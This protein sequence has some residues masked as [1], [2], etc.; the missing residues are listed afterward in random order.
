MNKRASWV[1]YAKGYGIVLVVYGHVSRGLFNAGLLLDAPRFT[2]IDSVIYSFHMPLFFFLSGL[3]FIPSFNKYGRPALLREKAGSIVYPYLVWSLLQG[4]IE[5]LLSRYTTAHVSSSEVLALLWQPRAQFW[6]LY[7]LFT[8]FGLMALLYR[9]PGAAVLLPAAAL[10]AWIAHLR[11]S[12]PFPLDF[13]ATYLLF[14]WL[15]TE[16]LRVQAWLQTHALAATLLCAAAFAALAYWL[17]GPLGLRYTSPSLLLLPL[18]LSGIALVCS[19]AMLSTRAGRALHWL[20]LCGRYSMTIYLMH[21]LV[22]SG[23]RIVLQKF[24][25]IDNSALHLLL[26][27]VIACA[28]P[29]GFYRFSQ[30]HAAL[31]YCFSLPPAPSA[32]LPHP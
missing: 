30:R 4:Y 10:L 19:L 5:V 18:A 27:C 22:G 13:I 11:L 21:I 29:I 23:V 25:G 8:L 28:L 20:Q 16:A 1:D 12:F 24:C 9:R 6:F 3:F 31:T 14:F 32:K 7:V 15:G 17:H 2:L 26:A